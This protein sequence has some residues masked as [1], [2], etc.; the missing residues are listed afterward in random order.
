F[1][2]RKKYGDSL[3]NYS[4]SVQ[5][6]DSRDQVEQNKKTFNTELAQALGSDFASEFERSQDYSYQQLVRLAKR[7]D[8]P[9]DTANTIY[10]LKQNAEQSIKVMRDD[11]TMTSDQRQQAAQQIR[12]QTEESVKSRLGDAL[13]QKYL[14][15]DGWWIR[16]LGSTPPPKR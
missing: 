11:A 9:S 14:N 16:N 8:L 4:D 1:D 5:S 12:A 2:L 10:D 6:Q 15:N 7:N 13:Y 3:Y